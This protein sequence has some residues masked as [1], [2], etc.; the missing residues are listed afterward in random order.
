M[1]A[2]IISQ[3]NIFLL[4]PREK[5]MI[6]NQISNLFNFDALA[7]IMTV[8]ISFVALTVSSFAARYMKGDAHYNKFFGLVGLLVSALIAM[9]SADNLFIFLLT[10]GIS[11]LILVILMIHKSSWK[12]A[13]ASG[14]LAVKIYLIGFLFI[15]FGSLLLYATTGEASIKLIVQNTSYSLSIFCAL[16]LLLVGAMTQ[17]AIF[18]FHKWLISS[19]NSPTP[20]SAIMHAGLVNGGGFLLVRFAPLY[21][22]APKILTIIFIIGLTTALIG[23]LWKL[24]QNDIKRMLAC[25]T[26]AQMGFMMAQ[27][28]L[29]LF[30]AAVAHLCYH[31]L[32][33][34]YLFL[35]S[36]S[37]A[38]EKKVDLAYPPRVFSFFCALL[39]GVVGSYSFVWV[40]SKEW[41]VY[42]TTLVIVFISFI[43]SSQFSLPILAKN[44]LR[45]L[46]LAAMATGIVGGMY[47]LSIHCI[48]S[49]VAHMNLLQPQPINIVH[50]VGMVLLFTSWVSILFARN[51]NN[52]ASTP[53]WMIKIYVKVVNS[54]QPH[55]STITTHRN[56]Y[57]YF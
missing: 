10:W 50:I 27:C 46:P 37:A 16:L 28:G 9:V 56:H 11:N 35:A 1:E 41:L 4:L 3:I 5:L 45:R 54:S 44:P 57:K 12:A 23:T 43:A 18:P 15:S 39:C 31:G 22:N 55:P 38:Q 34:A 25:S 53:D 47:G 48:E 7:V 36:G 20:I 42:D 40:N 29:G 32:F 30:P 52:K 6:P 13:K 19:L 33:K 14:M 21:L 49:L 26:I 17:S 8:L 2:H 51:L 24:V